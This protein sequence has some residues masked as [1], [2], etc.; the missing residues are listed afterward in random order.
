M[1]H[2]LTQITD[3]ETPSTPAPLAFATPEGHPDRPRRAPATAGVL[4][5]KQP[6]HD[7]V[8]PMYVQ[9]RDEIQMCQLRG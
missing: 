5:G 8:I 3:C 7:G 2:D 1:P 4:A 6:A 9:F